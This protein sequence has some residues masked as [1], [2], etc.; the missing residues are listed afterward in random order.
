MRAYAKDF[1]AIT[2][3]GADVR[4]VDRIYDLEANPNAPVR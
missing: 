3:A 4:W 2:S 1:P